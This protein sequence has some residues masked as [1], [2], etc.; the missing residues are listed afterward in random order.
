MSRT[1]WLIL[2]AAVLGFFGTWLVQP[3]R[4]DDTALIAQLA[5]HR[6]SLAAAGDALLALPSG[7]RIDLRDGAAA[8]LD[9]LV[10]SLRAAGVQLAEHD[11]ELGGVVFEV[12]DAGIG[13][14]G[15]S[16]GY[17]YTPAGRRLP[18]RASEVGDLAAGFAAARA[19]QPRHVALDALLVRPVDAS[20]ALLLETY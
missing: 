7:T 3:M 2:V 16:I 13:I 9:R 17:L 15:S 8:P 11:T 18:E 5:A 10:P 4:P 20:W 14:S 19:A 12:R 1:P 6:A